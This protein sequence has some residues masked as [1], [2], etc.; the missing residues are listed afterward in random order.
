[1]ARDVHPINQ[2]E[3]HKQAGE[4]IYSTMTNKA[5]IVHKLQNSLDNII[6]QYKLEK[7]SSQAKD[8]IIKSQEDLLIEIGY[9]PSDVKAAK[10][11]IKKKNED[12]VALKKQL[13]LPH[14]EHPQ[15]KEV[16]ECQTQQEEMM[17]LILQ[18]NDQLK[19]MEKELDCVIQLKQA[20]FEPTTTT[21]I[22]T[23]TTIVP[24]TL[25]ASLP[26]IAP[27]AIALTAATASTSIE[28]S[29][30]T[31]AQPSDEARKLVKAM[32]NM[33]IRT[34]E[35]NKLK[36]K[37][38]SLEDENKLAQVM[39]KNEVQKSTRLTERMKNSEKELTLKEPLGQA[40]QVIFE[41]NDLVKEATEAI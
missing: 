15:T 16:L 12:I 30:T 21:V 8:N 32:E 36:E 6:A 27:L 34:T 33:S 14:S 25:A 5:M 31:A 24:S 2:I 20:S 29:T 18:L 38:S 22:P 28:G 41:Q 37:I 35:I 10:K 26:P 3:F 23:V 1:L 13:K 39:H 4:I 9:N 17:D 11:L 40:I 7:A 19:E